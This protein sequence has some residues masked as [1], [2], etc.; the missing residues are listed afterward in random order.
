MLRQATRRQLL[1]TAATAAVFGSLLP[2]S[3]VAAMDHGSGDISAHRIDPMVG[4]NPS[5]A[6]RATS[7]RTADV[8]RAETN[9]VLTW[10]ANAGVQI[11]AM[12]APEAAA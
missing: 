1:A 11:E 5:V 6:S 10:L 2:S 7:G 9:V 4:S 12:A 8:V 3:R